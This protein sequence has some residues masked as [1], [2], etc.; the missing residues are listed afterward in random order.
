MPNTLMK[1]AKA[2]AAVSASPAP[3]SAAVSR[4]ARLER[5]KP[6]KN[7]WNRYHSLTNPAC[8]GIAD[9]LIAAKSAP[10]AEDPRAVAQNRR[11]APDR[12][13]R[14]CDRPRRP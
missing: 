8:G 5:W 2:I 3:A 12:S 10:D 1:V 13:P 11:A 14:P 4:L 9:R 7:V 6:W